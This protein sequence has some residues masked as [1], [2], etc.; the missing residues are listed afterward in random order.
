[1]KVDIVEC[2]ELVDVGDFVDFVDY[3]CDEL[4]FWIYVVVDGLDG[5]ICLCCDVC[6]WGMGVVVFGE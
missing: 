4:C 6:N 1:M 3:G 5:N 2:V